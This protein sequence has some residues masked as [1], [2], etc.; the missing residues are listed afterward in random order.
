[1]FSPL[2]WFQFQTFSPQWFCVGTLVLL[3]CL[4]KG[5]FTGK[6]FKLP[7]SLVAI[8]LRDIMSKCTCEGW[9]QVAGWWSADRAAHR[10]QLSLAGAATSFIFV[11][12]K[13]SSWQTHVCRNKYLSRQKFS[14]NKIWQT[15]FCCDKCYVTA[16]ILLSQQTNTCLSRQNFCHDKNDTC[17][18]S[19][20]W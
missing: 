6:L 14:C 13:V 10:W 8:T 19:R 20:Q 9:V 1:M 5:P 12:T 11:A 16:S 7:K 2:L 4:S 3:P 18:S 17:G 15:E